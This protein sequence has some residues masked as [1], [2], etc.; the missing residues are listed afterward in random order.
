MLDECDHYANYFGLRTS[1]KKNNEFD[2]NFT[3]RLS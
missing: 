1:K 3:T 2:K